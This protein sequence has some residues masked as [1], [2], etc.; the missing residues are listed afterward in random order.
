MRRCLN[1]AST[2]RACPIRTM[3]IPA[4]LLGYVR[5]NKVTH[6][7]LGSA[8]TLKSAVSY[9]GNDAHMAVMHYVCLHLYVRRADAHE[10]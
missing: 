1:S 10:R 9:I 3:S 6:R 5:V 8:K 4:L 2:L 7:N